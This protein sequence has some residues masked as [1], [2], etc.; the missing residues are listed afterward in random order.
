[1]EAQANSF[2][3]LAIRNVTY[4]LSDNPD[5][6]NKPRGVQPK[7]S[8]LGSGAPTSKRLTG[9]GDSVVVLYHPENTN[10]AIAWC[11]TL[12][13][14]QSTDHVKCHIALPTCQRCDAVRKTT[15]AGSMTA[16][17]QGAQTKVGKRNRA[18]SGRL[19]QPRTQQTRVGTD[20]SYDAL[21]ALQ[22][23][24]V[25]GPDPN[26]PWVPA[27]DGNDAKANAQPQPQPAAQPGTAPSTAYQPNTQPKSTTP[28]TYASSVTVD[29]DASADPELEAA[30]S[31]FQDYCENKLTLAV[32]ADCPLHIV[33]SWTDEPPFDLHRFCMSLR[34]TDGYTL[35][36]TGDASNAPAADV[37]AAA[38]SNT[39][40]QSSGDG[41]GSTGATGAAHKG[42]K[43]K[44]NGKGGGIG[45]D[46]TGVGAG[47]LD[48]NDPLVPFPADNGK[49]SPQ[50][51]PKPAGGK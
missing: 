36:T 4:C 22:K 1:M 37:G 26:D 9:V 28:R 11:N 30:I 13:A 12:V 19:G 44:G 24:G 39:D 33:K 17:T 7:A 40:G 3:W 32:R 10:K 16:G 29:D 43:D 42:G 31:E 2:G 41:K 25:G 46:Q 23:R 49:A 47:A 35:H 45:G 8:P 18:P 5:P 6:P 20:S 48:P 38:G 50:T 51:Q 14:F 21:V 15:G 34:G 27:P